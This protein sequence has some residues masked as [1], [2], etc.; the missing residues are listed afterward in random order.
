MIMSLARRGPQAYASM[1]AGKWERKAFMGSELAGKTLAVVGLGRIGREVAHRMR[2]FGMI[3]IGFDPIVSKTEAADFGV[4]V[5]PLDELFPRADYI[6]V[7]VPLIPQTKGASAT[8]DDER[9]LQ[10]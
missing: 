8:G 1:V 4:E 7:H 3:T 9:A 10:T 6:T 5:L 2:A